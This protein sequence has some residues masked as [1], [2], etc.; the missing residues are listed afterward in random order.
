[1]Y[2]HPPPCRFFPKG[3]C[4][5]GKF[6]KYAHFKPKHANAGT[7]SSDNSGSQTGD[8][9]E[10]KPSSKAKAKAKRKGKNAYVAKALFGLA[11]AA[12][13]T[14]GQSMLY[15]A[16]VAS[17]CDDTTSYRTNTDQD[18]ATNLAEDYQE[19]DS[20][21]YWELPSWA[22]LIAGGN[23]RHRP[24]F[25]T[26]RDNDQKS[27]SLKVR[28]PPA[29]ISNA[30]SREDREMPWDYRWHNNL[31]GYNPDNI[32]HQVKLNSLRRHGVK[33][34]SWKKYFSKE[35]ADI[36][37]RKEVHNNSEKNAR[38]KT[39]TRKTSKPQTH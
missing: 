21:F 19:D 23:F 1:L 2:A 18:C 25:G 6:C 26:L 39:L 17:I 12:Q 36:K 27:L 33:L 34:I 31:A 22:G 15:F 24:A 32:G 30:K 16:S 35:K 20:L 10:G 4:K 28:F 9:S 8:E 37:L 3:E 13:V 5:D 7:D 38:D 14:V 29:I 11:G